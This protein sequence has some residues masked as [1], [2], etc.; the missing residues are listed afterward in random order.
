MEW[1]LEFP[2]HYDKIF[3]TFLINYAQRIRDYSAKFHEDSNQI[4]FVHENLNKNIFS[5]IC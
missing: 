4:I 5:Q 1:L 2:F 3:Q